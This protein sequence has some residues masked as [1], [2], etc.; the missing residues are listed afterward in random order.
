MPGKHIL[1]GAVSRR[2]FFTALAASCLTLAGA[3]LSAFAAPGKK[4]IVVYFSMPEK[5]TPGPMSREEE[6]S[7]VTVS[8]KVYGNTEFVAGLIQQHTG[9][10]IFR[11]EPKTPYP[12]NHERLLRAAQREQREKAF[13]EIAGKIEGFASY[14]A[15]FLGYPIWWYDMPRILYTFLRDYD[16]SG[17]KVYPFVTH[18]G[19]SFTGT[20]D[21][22]AAL[23]PKA[24]VVRDGLSIYRSRVGGADPFVT[25]WLTRVG[26]GLA[27]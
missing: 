13:P 18:G 20:I 24:E 15:V 19:S 16:L 10:D 17:K 9:A 1:T 14:S 6:N 3:P 4:A 25:A 26:W 22:I 27:S 2:S 23:A 21:K 8:G 5:T 11:L 7:T 12:M